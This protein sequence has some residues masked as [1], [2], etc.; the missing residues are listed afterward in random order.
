MEK[1]EEK[2]SAYAE[3][4]SQNLDLIQEILKDKEGKEKEEFALGLALES[5][6]EIKPEDNE[7]LNWLVGVIKQSLAGD[8]DAI[9]IE[10]MGNE[11]AAKV[12]Y[13]LTYALVGDQ[14]GTVM[15]IGKELGYDL[16]D[17]E[18]AEEFAP[19]IENS[20][21]VMQQFKDKAQPT[22]KA[23]DYNEE[24]VK[25]FEEFTR[26]FHTVCENGK[27]KDADSELL[28]AI[29]SLVKAMKNN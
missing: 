17:D 21:K 18:Q 5:V 12:L 11:K 9:K 2:R 13:Q 22:V 19:I 25:E 3:K 4:L 28:G 7:G 15:Y 8:P 26:C 27:K 24:N 6:E 29:L 1:F 20:F 16:D 14:E 23:T 10:K